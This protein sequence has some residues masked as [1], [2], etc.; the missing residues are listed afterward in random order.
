MNPSNE[1]DTPIGGNTVKR[2]RPYQ[3]GLRGLI[4]MVACCAVIAW[5]GRVM[6]LNR[7]PALAEERAIEAR[8]SACSSRERRPLELRR[9]KNSGD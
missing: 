5:A 6:W 1:L 7:N 9:F 3:T 4:L 2:K 8:P